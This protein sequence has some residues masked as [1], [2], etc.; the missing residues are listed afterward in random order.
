MTNPTRHEGSA[1][2]YV[3]P[4][5]VELVGTG[6]FY[7]LLALPGSLILALVGLFLSRRE[8]EPLADEEFAARFRD[9]ENGILN[10]DDAQ[11]ET[12]K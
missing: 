2:F 4:V 8:A 11:P 5:R 12:R 10:E 6:V 7:G 1:P 3:D 9:L